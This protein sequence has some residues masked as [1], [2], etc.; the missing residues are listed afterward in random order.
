MVKVVEITTEQ[1]IA[2]IIDSVLDEATLEIIDNFRDSLILNSKRP[3]VDRRFF[4]DDPASR[5]F[6]S[7]LEEALVASISRDCHVFRY[8]RFLEYRKKGSSLNPHTD[9]TKVC[10]DTNCTSTH[11]LLLYLS[12]CQHGGETLLLKH[13]SWDAPILYPTKPKRGRILLFPHATPHAGAAVE[14]VPKVCLRAEVSL[15]K[16]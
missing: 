14:S 7:L 10:D 16:I 12:D 3:T 8:K 5:T 15:L 9:G 6:S 11:T 1:G 4:A 13:C 2:W